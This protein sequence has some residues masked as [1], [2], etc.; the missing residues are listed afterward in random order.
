MLPSM[1]PLL[2][3]LLAAA[4]L[5][6][7]EVDALEVVAV[8][9]NVYDCFQRDEGCAVRHS[10]PRVAG[11]E[12][13]RLQAEM[14]L[15][16][17]VRA[18]VN[19]QVHTLL[20]DFGLSTGAY[21]NNVSRLGLDL[22]RAEV[23][24]LSHAHED[25]YAGLPWAATQSK[26]PIYVGQEDA[27]APRQ[28]QSPQSTWDMGTLS[29]AALDVPKGRV[30]EA[31]APVVVAGAALLSGKIPQKT[32]Y[33]K[34]PPPLKVKAGNAW[35]AETMAHELAVAFRVRGKGL[36]VLTSC[37]HSGVVNTVEHFRAVTGE[38]RVLAIVGG[39]HLTQATDEVVAAT[40]KALVAMAPAW[41]APMHCTGDRAAAQL[42]AE[43]PKAYV[44]PAVG[45]RYVFTAEATDAGR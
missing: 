22:A 18:T 36:V 8:V 4:P 23:L 7:P 15:A 29:R 25:H 6:V 45:T 31:P 39:M 44:H 16:Y 2:A 3:S 17:F 27:F 40:V 24:V 41:V 20:F 19:G 35:V 11:F 13:I 28:F 32:P 5:T 37:A 43:L 21:Q 38:Q 9:D 42:R 14:G 33:E 1:L 12:A 30:V 34:V 26:A 10:I